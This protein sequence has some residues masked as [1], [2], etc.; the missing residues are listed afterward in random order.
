MCTVNNDF[1]ETHSYEHRLLVANVLVRQVKTRRSLFIHLR[2]PTANH[3][4]SIQTDQHHIILAAEVEPEGPP[5]YSPPHP[6]ITDENKYRILTHGTAGSVDRPTVT[7]CW[8]LQ[9]PL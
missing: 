7:H 6:P 4:T 8:L 1:A 9:V 2:L 5:T 3:L